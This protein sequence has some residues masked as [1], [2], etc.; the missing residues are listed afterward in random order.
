MEAE[1]D[2]TRK[3]MDMDDEVYEYMDTLFVI[4][5][6]MGLTVNV[7]IY[8]YGYVIGKIQPT[9]YCSCRN[10]TK[11]ANSYEAHIITFT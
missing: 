11:M 6:Y 7:L 1:E 8:T 2:E 5:F 9:L 4:Y 3:S 10:S